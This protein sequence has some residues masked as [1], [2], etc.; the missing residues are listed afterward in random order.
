ELFEQPCPAHD[1]DAAVTVAEAAEAAGVPMML[2]E[3][4][5]G[6]ADIERAADLR[7]ASYIKLKLMKAGGLEALA[8]DLKLIR[9]RGM[10]PVL[11]NGVAGD[12]GCWMEACAARGLIGNAGEMN[13]FL[14]PKTGLFAEPIAVEG[15]AMILDPATP[16]LKDPDTLA[17]LAAETVHYPESG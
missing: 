15:G 8:K 2:D 4:I 5:Y 11:G 12:A 7:A 17:T 3:S 13:G 14:K 10:T 1:W 6:P 16:K 9:E